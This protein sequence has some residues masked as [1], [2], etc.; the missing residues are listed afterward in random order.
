MWVTN[1]PHSVVKVINDKIVSSMCGMITYCQS[2]YVIS[3]T[4]DCHGSMYKTDK[5]E[6]A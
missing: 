4:V 1:N 5:Y 6:T 3:M 2:H